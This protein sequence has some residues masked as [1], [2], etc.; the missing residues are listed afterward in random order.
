MKANIKEQ[1]Y[2]MIKDFAIDN[3]R[4]PEV[5]GNKLKALYNLV[6]KKGTAIITKD[7]KLEGVKVLEFGE[8]EFI[9][10]KRTG[11]SSFYPCVLKTILLT[12][13]N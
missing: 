11:G 13:L 4:R 12:D 7:E 9:G 5:Q 10:F 2:W 1:N 8:G 3:S 6:Q